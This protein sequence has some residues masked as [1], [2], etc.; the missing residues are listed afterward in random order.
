MAALL[1]NC[2]GKREGYCTAAVLLATILLGV[3]A[4]NLPV[5]TAA[6]TAASTASVGETSTSTKTIPTSSET[7]TPESRI[8]TEDVP[9]AD[10][11][12]GDVWISPV[13]G[14][15]LVY[16]PAGDFLMGVAT[17]ES[18][19]QKDE[20]PQHSVTVGG[21][22]IDRTEVTNA[23]FAEFSEES[24]YQTDAERS[25]QSQVFDL[26]S[27]RWKRVWNASWKDP[28]GSGE[29][30]TGMD[31]Y[32]VIHMSWNDAKAYCAWAGRRL[33]TE[34]EWEKAARG[35]DGRKYPWGNGDIDGRKANLADINLDWLY[36][37]GSIND[38]YA[39]TA[40]VGSFPDGASPYGALDMIGNVK[41]WV[42][43]WYN[44]VYYAQTQAP[45][46]KGPAIGE[47]KVQRGGSWG[48]RPA[49]ITVTSRDSVSADFPVDTFGFRCAY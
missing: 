30:L 35:I 25:K 15:E 23:M 46:P 6:S 20:A 10:A 11:R 12:I 17:V 5:Q 45:N 38:G 34:S 29:K 24:K 13:D 1:R 48:T 8:F 47:F 41:E 44:E 27:G 22:W 33:P 32:P 31:D 4:C 16:V 37:D 18:N 21:F 42:F 14:A 39:Y 3:P 7:P 49:D 9:P 2:S 28:Q 26:A 40:P 19:A 43:D 36:S